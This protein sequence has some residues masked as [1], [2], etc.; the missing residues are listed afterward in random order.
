M[1]IL[2]WRLGQWHLTLAE[3]LFLKIVVDDR[4]NF[5]F[6]KKHEILTL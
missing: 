5:F 4:D 6:T 3:S 1:E 2:H